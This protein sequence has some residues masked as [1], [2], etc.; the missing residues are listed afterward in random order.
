MLG[1]IA[2][3]VF[4]VFGPWAISR[5]AV[6][7]V[8]EKTRDASYWPETLELKGRTI[9]FVSLGSAQDACKRLCRGLNRGLVASDSIVYETTVSLKTLRGL[10][11]NGEGLDFGPVRDVNGGTEHA[12]A[13]VAGEIDITILLSRSNAGTP[14]ALPETLDKMPVWVLHVFEGDAFWASDAPVARMVAVNTLV[15]GIMPYSR[16]FALVPE[17]CA[18]YT[19]AWSTWLGGGVG[20]HPGMRV[21][22]QLFK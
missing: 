17:G 8:E 16:R 21:C 5:F 6:W 20:L 22:D 11:S 7:R 3:A 12:F 4:I 13:D 18:D 1:A 15:R 19:E 9:L 2:V 14:L 10:R